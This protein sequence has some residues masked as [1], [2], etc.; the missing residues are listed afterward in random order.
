MHRK[1]HAVAL[2]SVILWLAGC[3]DGYTPAPP[4]T[5]SGPVAT[6]TP[7]PA[8]PPS[9]PSKPSPRLPSPAETAGGG[10]KGPAAAQPQSPP[11]KPAVSE[12]PQPSAAEQPVRLS[13]GVA[14]PQTGPQG[15]LMSFSVEYQAPPNDSTSSE[16]VW[17]IERAHGAPNKKSV[18]LDKQGQGTLS[19][20]INGWRPTEAPFQTHIEDRSG[21]RLSA[22]IELLG[23]GLEPQ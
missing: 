16:Y 14:L 13:M 8:P 2:V 15:T 12:S 1:V 18:R 6:P 9:A 22:S 11:V 21:Q 20:F 4:P 3:S 23:P 19:I 17:V 10:S 5:P 7:P